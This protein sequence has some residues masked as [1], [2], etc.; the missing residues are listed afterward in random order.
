MVWTVY[1]SIYENGSDLTDT[2][3]FQPVKFP[4]NTIVK[5]VRTWI[6]LASDPTFTDLNM[7]V[8]SNREDS[9]DP[10]P[11]VLLHTSTDTRLKSEIL[12][13]EDNGVREIYFTFNDI[14]LKANDTYHFVINGTGY[15]PT[16]SSFI[17][18]R[19]A[20]P[21][22]VY[23]ANYTPTANNISIAPYMITTFIGGDL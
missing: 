10:A 19:I 8:Y 1:G 11:G 16:S 3:L 2:T 7:K 5:G 20:W 4:E 23:T 22:P 15:S 6:I 21:D 12:T 13:T 18:W 9:G 14:N 17:A